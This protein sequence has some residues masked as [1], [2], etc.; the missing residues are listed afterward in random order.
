MRSMVEGF[1]RFTGYPGRR[2]S[3]MLRMVPLPQRGRTGKDQ[4]VRRLRPLARR[5]ATI[6][7]PFLV[8]IRERKP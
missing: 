6:F 2:P 5:R 8:A 1:I 3:T 7:C 4:A